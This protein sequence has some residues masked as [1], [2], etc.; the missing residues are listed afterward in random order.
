MLRVDPS[1]PPPS[2]SG[3]PRAH[4]P[5][6]RGDRAEPALTVASPGAPSVPPP[7]AAAAAAAAAA[8]VAPRPR[9]AWMRPASL[10]AGSA[11]L[12][13]VDLAFAITPRV[14]MALTAL[15][16][17]LVPAWVVAVVSLERAHRTL[18]GAQAEASRPRLALFLLAL[19]LLLACIGEKWLLV[20]Q[21][22][23]DTAHRGVVLYRS[24]T[25]LAFSLALGGLLGRR[26]LERLMATAAEHPARLMAVSFGVATLIGSFLLTLP[27]SL[28]HIEDASFVDGLFMS[29][30]AVCVTGLAVHGIAETYTPFGQAVLILLVQIGGLGIMVLST[31][32]A[33]LAGRRLRL[34]DAAV[35]AELIDAESFARLRRNVA[36]IVLFTLGVELVGAIALL[37][38]FL[39]YPQI[40]SGPVPGE[41]LSGAGD[42]LWAAVFH[43]V[44]AYC[45]AGFSLFGGGLVPLVG[46]P[47]VSAVVGGLVIFGSLGF[48]VHDELVR[49]LRL[50]LRGERPPRLSLHSRVVLLTTAV[51]L[52][53]GAAGFLLLEWRRSMAGLSWPVKV[54]ASFFQSAMTRSA[55][56]ST[57]DFG[58]MGP[59]ALM[60][61]SMMMFIGGAP[62]STSGGVKVTTVA[63]LFAA[64]RA[65]LR[66]DE[67]PHLL[68]RTLP[69]A[70]VR[71]ALGVAFLSMVLVSVFVL[72]LL[73]L[74]PHDPMRLAMEAVS[75][76]ATA[77]LSANVTPSLSAPGK[78]VVTL[79]MFIG[80]IGPLTMALALANQ[81]RARSYRLPEERVG[82]G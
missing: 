8:A 20:W 61:T 81:A 82:I 57:I 38:S 75:A 55:G 40:A 48:P 12:L 49:R 79:A 26:P 9:A 28:R 64:L 17:L 10:L 50:R 32:F 59:A 69:A 71:R 46:T 54:M 53:A 24:Y 68:G 30:S 23:G 16:T 34:R 51:L 39:P 31:F 6:G 60:L 42:H 36:A 52:V 37:F 33:I 47:A 63:A 19:G 15:E 22:A 78:V 58:L 11:V 67:A 18:T 65:E 45:N 44:S 4:R 80:R 56:L 3:A 5:G 7:S 21:P 13:G 14:S 76:F 35:M 43:A 77:G 73:A 72:I 2:W 66:G 41:P 62:G 25:V 1:P 70:T 27:Q 29:A 74:E